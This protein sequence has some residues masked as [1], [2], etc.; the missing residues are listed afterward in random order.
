MSNK[1]GNITGLYKAAGTCKNDNPISAI[2]W[3]EIKEY[4]R[5]LQFNT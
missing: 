3:L 5:M 4:S 1:S 2:G